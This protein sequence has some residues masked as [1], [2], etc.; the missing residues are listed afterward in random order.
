MASTRGAINLC[1]TCLPRPVLQYSHMMH[2][3]MAGQNQRRSG[4]GT[5]YGTFSIWCTP[6]KSTVLCFLPVLSTAEGLSGMN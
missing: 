1:L 6:V 3:V 5:S 2:M 4:T